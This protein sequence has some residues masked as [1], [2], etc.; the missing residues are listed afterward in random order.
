VKFTLVEF[1]AE[2]R[3][4]VPTLVMT[5]RV[6]DPDETIAA[7]ALRCQVQ[8]EPARRSYSDDEVRRLYPLFG[9]RAEF[10][11]TQRSLLWTHVDAVI[12][13]F[14]AQPEV[15]LLLP[16]SFDLT[17]AATRL[18]AALDAGDVPLRLL[19]SGTIFKIVDGAVST[20]PVPWTAELATRLPV[21]LWREVIDQH[22]PGVV[23][24]PIQRD[25]VERLDAHRLARGLLTWDRALADLLRTREGKP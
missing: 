15:R 19:F 18:F 2:P 12:P 22:Y 21:A 9:T 13:G 4:A 20:T 25:L 1:S 5:L 8:I 11:R 7:L 14:A 6:D 16:C 24:I 3:A 17:V 10:D 23:F